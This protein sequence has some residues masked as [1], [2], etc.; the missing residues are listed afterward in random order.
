MGQVN[1]RY[2]LGT[3]RY[4][5]GYSDCK[6]TCLVYCD[7]CGSF[8]IREYR[9]LGTLARSAIGL[10]ITAL[11][12]TAFW[13]ICDRYNYISSSALS[14]IMEDLVDAAMSLLGMSACVLIAFGLFVTYAFYAIGTTHSCSR[15]GNT[16]I[17]DQ[18]VLGYPEETW[19]VIDVPSELTHI[20]YE[21]TYA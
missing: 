15:C 12:A 10:L 7:K 18:N 5:D 14:S 21:H 11:G 6:I 1:M 13:L 9:D 16:D 20:H 17:S 8:D 19:N 3:F 2:E 4:S